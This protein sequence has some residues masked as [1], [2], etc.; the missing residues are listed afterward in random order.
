MAS[1]LNT[2]P[3]LLKPFA[4]SGDKNNIPE[5]ATGTQ[6]ASLD[7]GFPPVTSLPLTQ[8]GIPPERKDFNGL[9]NLL[10]KQYFYLQNG[11]RFTF[12]QAVSDAIGGYP[13]NATLWFKDEALGISY[14]VTSLIN[15][16]TYNFVTTPSYIDGVKWK[17]VIDSFPST[18]ISN[19][20][21]EIPQD[22]KLELNNGTLTLKA[23]SKTTKLDGTQVNI[24]A[25]RS[26][27][28]NVNTKWFVYCSNAG[29]SINN[30]SRLDKTGSGS[31]LPEDDTTYNYFYNTTENKIYA[32]VRG[33]WSEQTIS[34]PI[35]IVTVSGG[36]ISSIDQVFNG[37]GYMGST[38]F[39]LP[40]V[41]GL[42]PNG[43][44]D[45]G[46]LK[47]IEIVSS[48]VWTRTWLSNPNYHD[49][50][51]ATSGIGINTNPY[52]ANENFVY[53][54]GGAKVTDRV[55]FGRMEYNSSSPWNVTKLLVKTA[56]HAVDYN[57]FSDLSDKV[58]TNTSNITTL[59]STKQDVATAVNYDNISNCITEIPQDIKLEINSSGK[60]V[61]K[62]GSKFYTP[63]GSNNFIT[64]SN[65]SDLTFNFTNTQ[66]GKYFLCV[67]GNNSAGWAQVG[68][69]GSGTSTE[70]NNGFYYRT[71]DNKIYYQNNSSGN[72]YSFPL[73]IVTATNGVCVIDQV[74]N[75][76]GYIGST[77]FALPGVKGIIP[78]GRNEDGSLKNIENTLTRV[79]TY[80]LNPA[81]GTNLSGHKFY[82]RVFNEDYPFPGDVQ[83]DTRILNGKVFPSNYTGYFYKTDENKGYWV[84]SGVIDVQNPLYIGASFTAN[85]T[86]STFTVGG[87]WNP[88]TAFSAVD[89][90]DFEK[91]MLK[92]DWVRVSTA[93]ASPDSSKFY[94]IPEN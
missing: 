28:I 31:S 21:T 90:N 39:A 69:T 8:G 89:Y 74:F 41:K 2:P 58:A 6:Q 72:I 48:Q 94:Y 84:I 11:G 92:E 32:W 67:T 75:G 22:I 55:V 81:W 93:P 86:S 12:N 4:D 30:Y 36:A 26:T 14:P 49:L 65:T 80:W 73:A 87:N 29:T 42:I 33:A 71:D 79:H 63:N 44:N 18:Q 3:V 50:S 1:E 53:N 45:D 62:A 38:V 70:A 23:G 88:K 47:N 57:D 82:L 9:G 54:A 76:F 64:Y 10:S 66:T 85:I 61:L 37:F 68:L 77:I 5:T 46:T 25:D 83:P 40:G 16:N 52:N 56:F 17:R 13:Q 35:C 91:A 24:T 43:R 59:Q 7:E 27:T 20:L 34:F 15:N 60:P 51:L 19:C 78:N